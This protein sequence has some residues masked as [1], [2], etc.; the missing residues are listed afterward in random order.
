VRG[1]RLPCFF[2]YLYLGDV[3]L[4]GGLDGQCRKVRRSRCTN[5]PGLSAVLRMELIWG[6]VPTPAMHVG[7]NS[8]ADA[9][10]K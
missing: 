9:V 2:V 8:E 7:I 10:N 6:G 3:V 4:T 1:Q 5:P